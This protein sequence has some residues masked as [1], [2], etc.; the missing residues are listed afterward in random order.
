MLLQ[1]EDTSNSTVHELWSLLYDDAPFEMSMLTRLNENPLA[2]FTAS[3][4]R[5]LPA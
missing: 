3:P 1:D 5:A 2:T 4:Y